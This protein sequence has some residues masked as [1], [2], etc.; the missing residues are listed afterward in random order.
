[1]TGRFPQHF[2]D[3]IRQ[4]LPV[5]VVVG[6]RVQLKRKGAEMV[7]LSP[8]NK[9]KS[10]SFTVTDKKQFWHDFS[11]GKHGDVF[12]FVMETEGV[13]FMGAVE[14]CAGLAGLPLPKLEGGGGGGGST[15]NGAPP[16]SAPNGAG[17]HVEVDPVDDVP[18]ADGPDDYGAEQPARQDRAPPTRTYAYED[19]DG[20]T[21][22]EVCR[23]EW[24]EGTKRRKRFAQRRPLDGEPG[25]HVWGLQAGLYVRSRSGDF[26]KLTEGNASWSGERRE[27]DEVAHG[28]Y[29]FPQLLDERAQGDEARTVFLPE[30]EKKAEIL[31]AWE[32]VATTNSGGATHWAHHMAAQFE[33]LN[34][35]IMGDND[36]PGRAGAHKRAASLRGIA[37]RVR[38]LE[39]RDHWS[40]CPAKGNVDDWVEKGGGTL[41]LF[42]EIVDR[43]PDWTPPRPE[44]NFGAFTWNEI[45][46]PGR[47]VEWLVKHVLVRRGTSV[48]FGPP[49]CGKSFLVTDLAL[50]VARGISWFGRRVH[51]GLVIY[52]AVEGGDGFKRRMKAYR[53]G[54]GVKTSEQP[55]IIILPDPINIF[56]NGDADVAKL[57]AEANAWKLYYDAGPELIVIDTLAAATTGADENNAKDMGPVLERCKRITRET[58]AHVLLVHHSN[59]LGAKAR[60][61]SGLT[62]NVDSVFEVLQTDQMDVEDLGDRKRPRHIKQVWARKIKEAEGN[63]ALSFILKQEILGIDYDGEQI[64]SC[65]VAAAGADTAPQKDV[66]AGYYAMKQNNLAIMQALVRALAKKGVYR[67]D[68]V[69]CPEHARCVRIADWQEELRAARYSGDKDDP[70]GRKLKAKIKKSV[71]RTYSEYGWADRLNLIGKHEEW[72]WRTSRPIHGIDP[73]PSYAGAAASAPLLAPGEDPDE[74]PF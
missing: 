44:S 66:P 70:D 37:R 55:N 2:L 16:A 1:M 26:V 28:L 72:V 30:G 20:I 56:Q 57:I 50:A 47:E 73:P 25:R 34:V 48:W 11:S 17:E 18:W 13:D 32:L 4:R 12:A 31:A 61:W 67:P 52:G 40:A 51:Q 15:R 65:I 5:S 10:P 41:E 69:P 71:D 39:W 6:R 53:Q 46:S 33:G 54:K 63:W 19:A 35:V 58:G 7:G 43:L 42:H 49:G 45:D 68:G 60:G 9:E 3:D 8:F 21:R 38:V 27:F 36:K 64:D 74:M 29:R 24:F 59:A 23:F 62:G 22:Y 14:V